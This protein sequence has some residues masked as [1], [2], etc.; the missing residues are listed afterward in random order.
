MNESRIVD[1]LTSLSYSIGHTV[2]TS[3]KYLIPDASVS[4]LYSIL[5]TV[6]HL[7]RFASLRMRNI[8]SFVLLNQFP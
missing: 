1:K 3:S 5:R 2:A 6:S 7:I 8:F 4:L